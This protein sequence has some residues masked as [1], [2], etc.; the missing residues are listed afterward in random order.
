[1]NFIITNIKPISQY[2]YLAPNKRYYSKRGK[3]F[4]KTFQEEI[5]RQMKIKN[6]K[7]MTSHNIECNIVCYFDNKRKN[8]LDNN[9][10]PILDNLEECNVFEDDRWITKIT[11]EK[12][13]EKPSRRTMEIYINDRDEDSDVELGENLD[14]TILQDELEPMDDYDYNDSFIV[15]DR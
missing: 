5:N 9:V 6:Y 13:Y 7:M 12:V 14:D 3:E 15:D 11:I 10:K 4:K 8:D 1:M 2:Q